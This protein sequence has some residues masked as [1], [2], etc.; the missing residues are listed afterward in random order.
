MYVNA[1]S[2]V[3]AFLAVAQ[4]L[5]AFMVVSA[6]FHSVRMAMR[7]RTA[8][9]LDA[10]ETEQLR[11]A[12]PAVGLFVVAF[13]S[14][15]LLMAVLD[16]YVSEWPTTMCIQGVTH[17]GQRSLSVV[18]HLP[19]MLDV[20]FVTKPLLLFCAA[21]WIVAH[22]IARR[23]PGRPGMLGPVL[24]L[25]LG[26][27]AALDAVVE[28]SY[29]GIPKEDDVL[30]TGCCMT[31]PATLRSAGRSWLE[32]AAPSLGAETSIVL[33]VAA[34]I[35]M[36]AA[37]VPAALRPL[38]RAPLRPLVWAGVVAAAS[39][40]AVIAQHVVIAVVSPAVHGVASH[41]CGWCVVERTT[42]GG[43]AMGLVAVALGSSLLAAFAALLERRDAA[44][45]AR[46]SRRLARIALS[47]L[48]AATVLGVLDTL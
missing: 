31:V 26:A 33:L 46:M 6:A 43:A 32:A 17:I 4:A 9:E 11:P 28:L 23:A 14:W 36:A 24:L 22:S 15:P 25:G 42:F 34:L 37:L 48:V 5:F 16:S 13:A 18:R 19:L 12:L 41:R 1:P 30:S 21:A 45:E 38:D 39:G 10:A 35:A 27:L 29:L 20:L 47:A 44:G 7:A 2:V 8:E 40:V 3:A